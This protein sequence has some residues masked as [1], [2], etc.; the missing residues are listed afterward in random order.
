IHIQAR[1]AKDVSPLQ[2]HHPLDKD[3]SRSPVVAD[4]LTIRRQRLGYP[5]AIDHPVD[6][7]VVTVAIAQPGQIGLKFRRGAQRPQFGFFFVSE[8]H[9]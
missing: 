4:K 3:P 9:I 8:A 5:L 6:H 1:R 2:Q 7:K